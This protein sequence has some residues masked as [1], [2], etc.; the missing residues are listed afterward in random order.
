[1]KWCFI[2]CVVAVAVVVE[3]IPNNGSE[4]AGYHASVGI[5]LAARLKKLEQEAIS[6]R[7]V[8]GSPVPLGTHPFMASFLNLV[9]IVIEL[10]TPFTSVCGASLLTHTR[11]LTA[12]HCWYDGWRW[13]RSFTM[14]F[15]SRTLHVGGVRIDTTD[16]EMHPNWDTSTLH[17]D[18]A[19][20]RH[21]WVGFNNIISP[22][23]LPM[24]QENDDFV[25]IWAVAIGYGRTADFQ[26]PTFNPDQREA[27]LQVI[28]N[29]QCAGTWS[30][31]IH[32]TLCTLAPRGVNTCSGDSGGP[33]VVG[34]GSD[35]VLIGVTS[36]GDHLCEV[37]KPS[38]F[39]RVTSF[40][41]WILSRS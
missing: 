15:G 11:S 24:G 1:M 32:S 37:E 3:G 40:I 39:A 34:S 28:T 36:F 38:G 27:R 14:V 23:R 8:G 12:A 9:G 25:G 7:I 4:W 31:V 6:S 30:N 35:R 22:I 21:D 5:P 2:V 13:A 29:Q 33:L 18:I 41:P 20:V 10:Y 17:N 26:L 16:V 19:I